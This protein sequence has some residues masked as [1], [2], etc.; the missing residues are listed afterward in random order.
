MTS[1]GAAFLLFPDAF[2]LRRGHKLAAHKSALGGAR[3]WRLPALAP[4]TPPRYW[5][6]YDPGF[7]PGQFV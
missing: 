6:H 1:N 3:P 5:Q 7:L 4:P 2:R